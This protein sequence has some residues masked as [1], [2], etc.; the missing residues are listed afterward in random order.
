MLADARCKL[1]FRIEFGIFIKRSQF[2]QMSI[3]LNVSGG[4]QSPSHLYKSTKL[5][6][7]RKYKR[8]LNSLGSFIAEHATQD[9][10]IYRFQA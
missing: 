6:G 8:H 9:A 3:S 10:L 1:G 4:N 5:Y 7:E 2:N